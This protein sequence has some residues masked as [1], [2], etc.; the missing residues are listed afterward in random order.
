MH[1]RALLQTRIVLTVGV[2]ISTLCF[3]DT[4]PDQW[5]SE[6]VW[7][8]WNACLQKAKAQLRLDM[9]SK[10]CGCTIDLAR[11]KGGENLTQKD[12][13]ECGDFAKYDSPLSPAY[14][15]REDARKSSW[16]GLSR[17]DLKDAWDTVEIVQSITQCESTGRYG[18]DPNIRW[19]TCACLTDA[20][21]SRAAKF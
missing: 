5:S 6:S 1:L 14:F 20:R 19:A 10:Y 15:A 8:G 7:T 12:L 18:N 11:I 3:A 2:L 13:S 21:R 9:A 4:P 17:E 16:L